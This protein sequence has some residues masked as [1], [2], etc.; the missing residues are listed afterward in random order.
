MQTAP[1][2]CA[3]TGSSGL[4]NAACGLGTREEETTMAFDEKAAIDRFWDARARGDYFP[5]DWHDRLSIE[6]AYR[7]Q[8]GVVARRAAAG[9]RQV[10]WKVGM[11]AEAMRRQFGFHE[12]VFGCLMEDGIRHSGHVFGADELIRPGFET[13]VCVR[14]REPLSG[15]VDAARA[16]RAVEACFPALEIIET[17]GDL[18]AQMALALA[19]NAQQKAFV[20]GE[21]VPWTNDLR[22]AE[23]EARV[24]VNGAEVARARGEAVMGDPLNSVVWLAGKLSEFGLALRPGD[25]IMTGSFTRQFPLAPSD[26]VRAEFDGLGTVE[27]GVA[28]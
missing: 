11:T 2:P 12:P 21:T 14:L 8:L 1:L 7:V 24:E 17:R 16:R 19:D 26:R 4:G 9:E 20:L 22:L 18:V 28:A 25:L 13:E 10:G 5:A 6:Q 3:P 15:T 23:A 27:V